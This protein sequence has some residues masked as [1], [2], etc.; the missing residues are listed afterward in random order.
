[1]VC[2]RAGHIKATA[3]TIKNRSAWRGV[4]CWILVMAVSTASTAS[5]SFTSNTLVLGGGNFDAPLPLSKYCTM[6]SC[7]LSN[8]A[9]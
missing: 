3:A 9:N 6:L 2:G 5:S 1:M 8:P 7:G 4:S